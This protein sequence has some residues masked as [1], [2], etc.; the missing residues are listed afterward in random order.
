VLCGV[1]GGGVFVGAPFASLFFTSRICYVDRIPSYLGDPWAALGLR[2][3]ANKLRCERSSVC[4][5]PCA[6]PVSSVSSSYPHHA[7]PGLP[8]PSQR[9]TSTRTPVGLVYLPVQHVHT[10]QTQHRAMSTV[11]SLR[12]VT[13][14]VTHHMADWF[15]F[16]TQAS[17]T[18]PGGQNCAR[19]RDLCALEDNDKIVNREYFPFK[20]VLLS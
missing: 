17:A 2:V 15:R 12:C 4:L 20:T 16:L 3:G 7:R 13:V 8:R 14:S 6:P 11:I 10:S 5:D 19:Q 18:K 1:V 9:Q